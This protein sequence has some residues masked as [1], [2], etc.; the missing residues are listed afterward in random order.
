MPEEKHP[1]HLNGTG[2]NTEDWHKFEKR[3]AELETEADVSEGHNKLE[4]FSLFLGHST[5]SWSSSA[6]FWGIEQQVGAV[7]H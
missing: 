1:A 2:T 3:M 6:C 5:T 7:R 4:Q